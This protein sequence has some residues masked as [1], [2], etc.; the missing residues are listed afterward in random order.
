VPKNRK[1]GSDFQTLKRG[2]QEKQIRE[3]FEVQSSTQA[4]SFT[5]ANY[6]ILSF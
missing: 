5:S 1:C 4:A 6:N 2:G 3:G